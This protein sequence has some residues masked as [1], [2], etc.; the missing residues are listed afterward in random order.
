MK[1]L[2]T[3]LVELLKIVSLVLGIIFMLLSIAG[4]SEGDFLLAII[5]FFIGL[6]LF[7]PKGKYLLKKIKQI[8]EN[9]YKKKLSNVVHSKQKI[10]KKLE[11]YREKFTFGMYVFIFFF[12]FIVSGIIL[13]IFYDFDTS[14]TYSLW[15]SILAT[16]YIRF[17]VGWA[18]KYLQNCLQE[19]KKKKQK[20]ELKRK[21]EFEEVKEKNKAPHYWR[22][23]VGKRKY[24]EEIT[25]KESSTFFAK[26]K[27]FKTKTKA[28]KLEEQPSFDKKQDEIEEFF[29][30]L[31]RKKKSIAHYTFGTI[32]NDSNYNL[33]F[34]FINDAKESLQILCW[35]IDERLLSEMLWFIKDKNVHVKIITKNRTNKG[36]LTEFKRYCSN[37]KLETSHRNKIHAKLIVKD[38][39]E[40]I[41]GSSNFTEASMS[42]SGHFLDCNIITKHRETIESAIDLFKSLFQNKDH[43][44]AIQ[45]SKL[46]YSRNHKEYLPFSLKTYFEKE[47]EEITL[48]F[49]CNQVDK[50]IIDRIIEWNP[51]TTIKLYVS[52][53]W[54][55]SELSNDNLNSMKWLYEASIN[56]YKNVN[57]I[58]VT[59]DVHSKLYLFKNQNTAFIS[60]QNLTVESWQSLLEAGILSDDNKD[61]KYL[62]DSI[63]SEKK[64][65][66]SKIEFEDLEETSKPES[67]FSGSEHEISMSVPWELPEAN[68][69]WRIPR[70]RN[71]SYYKLVKHKPKQKK[72]EGLE[73]VGKRGESGKI[74]KSPLLE[75]LESKYLSKQSFTGL[76]S[77]PTRLILRGKSKKEEK[78]FWENELEKLNKK[79]EIATSDED[80]KKYKEAINYIEKQLEKFE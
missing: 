8:L 14:L 12:Y 15:F 47:S 44:K 79:Y 60:S 38:N 22:E 13:I 68:T 1:A 69:K 52:D 30:A 11:E 9:Q 37:L 59:A 42:E 57:V 35:R 7:L 18:R 41:L 76:Y 70:T 36:Y 16:A 48:L 43:T 23:Y 72:E 66:L 4:F 58:P 31:Q 32:L 65:Q 46:M 67:T 26:P 29:E 71:Q 34:S 50:R 53:T 21:N 2:K 3:I 28:S 62:Y 33:F 45:D 56:N 10:E 78:Q 19:I 27:E 80:K 73:N 5:V 64:S 49:S 77:K 63:N 6:L 75:E 20:E 40:L 61:L 39:R 17:K 24:E 74:T 55:T 25:E 51:K 54:T